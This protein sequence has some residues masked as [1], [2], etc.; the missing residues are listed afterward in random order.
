MTALM[1]A[2]QIPNNM[3]VVNTLLNH[4]SPEAIMTTDRTGK[5]AAD[6]AGSNHDYIAA[7]NNK[8][9]VIR[10]TNPKT[11]LET[12]RRGTTI[13]PPM[14]TLSATVFAAAMLMI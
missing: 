7:I 2:V 13:P 11:I 5:S 10:G 8:S 14:T 1:Y 12:V 4:M 9:T 3:D 6:Y